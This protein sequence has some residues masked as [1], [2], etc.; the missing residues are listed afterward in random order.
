LKE[1]EKKRKTPKQKK[2]WKKQKPI[3]HSS[4][5]PARVVGFSWSKGDAN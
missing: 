2:K 3:F 1:E 5:L 4:P